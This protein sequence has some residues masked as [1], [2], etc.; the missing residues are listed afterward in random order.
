MPSSDLRRFLDSLDMRL[1]LIWDDLS[2]FVQAANSI[3]QSKHSIDGELYQK[4]M[5]SIHY[6][7][8]NLRF[9]TSNVNETIR[10]ALLAFA[11]S[12]FLRWP[13]I[14]IRC[15]HLAQSLKSTLS[16]LTTAMPTQLSL[17]LYVIGAVSVFDESEQAWLQPALTE[18][19]E[20]MRLGLT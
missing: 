11:S 1:H 20:A 17:W 3:T 12:I 10:F 5:I 16:L 4:V 13:G 2:E 18:V 15:E 8:I 9:D 6:R 19:L 7:L 14:K